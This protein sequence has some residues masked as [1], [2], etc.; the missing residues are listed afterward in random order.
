V[1]ASN[2][3]G[4]FEVYV[5]RFPDDGTKV[6]VSRGGGRVSHW[7]PNGREILYQ[8][9]EQRLMVVSYRVEDAT[10]VVDSPNPWATEPIGDTGVLPGFDIAPDGERV[11]ALMPA[12]ISEH[13]QAQNTVTLLVNCFDEVHRR[14]GGGGR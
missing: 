4:A 12:A 10:F 2:E 6:R 13:R 14:V 1:W 5:R 7:S 3:S 11:A 8:T 9:D